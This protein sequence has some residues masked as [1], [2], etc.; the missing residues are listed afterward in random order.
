MLFELKQGKVGPH[1][2]ARRIRNLEIHRLL[3]RE[4]VGMQEHRCQATRRPL[5]QQDPHHLA[6]ARVVVIQTG[7][8]HHLLHGRGEALSPAVKDVV[9]QGTATHRAG[10]RGFA[11][12]RQL[13]P[14]VPVAP[15]RHGLVLTG[16]GK[17]MAALFWEIAPNMR[18]Q[19]WRHIVLHVQD[20]LVAQKGHVLGH[21]LRRPALVVLGAVDHHQRR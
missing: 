1:P 14:V 8:H 10:V 4:F 2:A 7:V 20:L 17:K 11:H 15:Q 12:L 9:E 5:R 19:G 6:R 21:T 13:E 3:Q 16:D 18:T